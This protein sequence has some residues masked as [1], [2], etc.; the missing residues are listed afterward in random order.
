MPEIVD[1]CEVRK[2]NQNYK[3]VPSPNHYTPNGL[4][5]LTSSVFKLPQHL[6]CTGKSAIVYICRSAKQL[7]LGGC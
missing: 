2:H 1:I 5:L 7:L 6:D 3:I 4:E